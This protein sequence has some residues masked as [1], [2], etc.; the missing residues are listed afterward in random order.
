MRVLRAAKKVF[1]LNIRRPRSFRTIAIQVFP[2]LVNTA[3]QP[4]TLQTVEQLAE[5]IAIFDSVSLAVQI[6]VVVIGKKIF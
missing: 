4:P 3:L 6:A 5:S 1:N 2:H